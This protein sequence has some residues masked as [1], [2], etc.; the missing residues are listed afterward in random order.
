ML[1]GREPVERV[2]QVVVVRQLLAGFAGERDVDEVARH[3]E[4]DGAARTALQRGEDHRVCPVAGLTGPL[5]A[6]QQEDRD[7]GALERAAGG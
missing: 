3:A 4:R 5:V 6:S 1:L 7:P 2:Q